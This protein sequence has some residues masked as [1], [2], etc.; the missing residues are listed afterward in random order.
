MQHLVQGTGPWM[1]D[2]FEKRRS[3]EAV[4]EKAEGRD[5]DAGGRRHR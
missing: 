2:T 4:E 1:I 3:H 5:G